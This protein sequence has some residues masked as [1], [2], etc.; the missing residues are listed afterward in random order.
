MMLVD[1]DLG[2]STARVTKHYQVLW[3]T[4]QQA[5]AVVVVEGGSTT[6]GG[7]FDGSTSDGG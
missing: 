2:C 7:A 6:D 5:G 4:P 3:G 1:V